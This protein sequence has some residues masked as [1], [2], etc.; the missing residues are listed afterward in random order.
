VGKEVRIFPI[1]DCNA[2]TSPHLEPVMA[3]FSDENQVERVTVNYEFQIG[4]NEMLRIRP[5][6]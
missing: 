5:R 3:Q 6:S 4:G 2:Q 1:V